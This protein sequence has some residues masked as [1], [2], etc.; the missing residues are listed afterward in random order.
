MDLF[1]IYYNLVKEAQPRPMPL[2]RVR[3]PVRLPPPRRIAPPIEARPPIRPGEL[4]PV[5]RTP[6]VPRP[7][8][9]RPGELP[10]VP[11]TPVPKY[12]PITVGPKGKLN[13]PRSYADLPKAEREAAIRAESEA[14]LR[15]AR[16]VRRY[17]RQESWNSAKHYLDQAVWNAKLRMMAYRMGLATPTAMEGMLAITSLSMLYLLLTGQ[18]PTSDR[19]QVAQVVEQMTADVKPPA[20]IL[21]NMQKSL[22][23]AK[24]AIT[25]A[26]VSPQL[27]ENAKPI[28]STYVKLVDDI[29]N[30]INALAQ[31]KLSMNSAAEAA[32]YTTQL[33]RTE[34]GLT[35]KL[36]TL[37]QLKSFFASRQMGAQVVAIDNLVN[38]IG[39]FLAAVAS[40]R[41]TV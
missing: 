40:S 2:P 4:P 1:D 19:P 21:P 22:Q 15:R 28:V 33:S 18:K 13:I 9:V 11:K 5:P 29:G 17:V 30:D 6:G 31:S 37:A 25:E 24:A 7:P 20:P 14:A 12:E 41:G 3:P 27:D 16:D 35:D 38:S 39:M 34:A 23:A 26:A 8:S 10:P 32:S 36:S